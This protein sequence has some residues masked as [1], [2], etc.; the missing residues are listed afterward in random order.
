MSLFTDLPVV[1]A[2]PGPVAP[3]SP[4]PSRAKVKRAM[5]TFGVIVTDPDEHRKQLARKPRKCLSCSRDFDST[6]PGNRICGDCKGLVAWST[7]NDF[8]IH[9]SF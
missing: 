9:A 8:S 5:P 1:T 3:R 6:G 4:R 2:P 7:P